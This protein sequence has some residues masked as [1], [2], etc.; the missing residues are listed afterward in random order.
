MSSNGLTVDVNKND[1]RDFQNAMLRAE[2]ETGKT[3][4]GSVKW[5]AITFAQK[6]RKKSEPGEKKRAIV[7]NPNRTG[8]GQRAK[9]AKY[10]I[11]VKTQKGADRYIPTNKKSDRRAKISRRGLAQ[12]S[13]GFMLRKLGQSRAGG[14]K[15]DKGRGRRA[16][17][18]KKK[19]QSSIAPEILLKNTLDYIS[20]AYP[21][22]VEESLREATRQMLIRIEKGVTKAF[23]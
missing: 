22:I 5:G 1:I 15:V 18:V 7:D 16:V 9:G 19:L 3:V 10:L 20:T 12:N 6:A 11:V 4:R 2:R 17:V 21:G 13:W 23:K 8:R 14:K